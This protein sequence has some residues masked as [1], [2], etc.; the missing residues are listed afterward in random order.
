MFAFDNSVLNM[1]THICSYDQQ[2]SF[3]PL[4]TDEKSKKTSLKN[5]NLERPC[6]MSG[7]FLQSNL[8]LLITKCIE[9]IKLSEHFHFESCSHGAALQHMNTQPGIKT[10]TQTKWCWT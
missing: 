1:H 5:L 9:K 10:K 8:W 3:H 6:C 4:P 2:Y 7:H